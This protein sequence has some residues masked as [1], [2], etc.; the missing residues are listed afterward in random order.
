MKNERRP[1]ITLHDSSCVLVIAA[2][3]EA[4]QGSPPNRAATLQR[5]GRQSMKRRLHA[6]FA[7]IG[8]LV[9]LPLLQVGIARAT[10]P[11]GAWS[12]AGSMA[13]PR[14]SATETLL[15]NGQVLVAGGYNGGFVNSAELYD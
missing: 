5:Q 12:S 10:G 4:P 6:V 9:M 13:V 3:V 1:P 7:T 11:V 14:R 15:Q 8:L 2:G